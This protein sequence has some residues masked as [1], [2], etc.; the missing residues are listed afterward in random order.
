MAGSAISSIFR[1]GLFNN[2]VA[3][4]TGGGTGIG[5]TITKELLFL[6]CK[7]VIASRRV[8][9]LQSAT[10]ELKRIIDPS[11]TADVSFVQCNIR[12]EEEVKHLISTTL[13][14]YGKLD[15]LVNNGGGQFYSPAEKITLKGWNAV[16]ETN[17]TGTFLMCREAYIQWMENHGG[18]IVTIITDMWKGWPS[19]SHSGAAR[20][21]V[22]NLTKSLAIEWAHTGVRVNC[23]APGSSIYSDT[24][25]A[26]Y[27]SRDFFGKNL[28]IVPAK[29]FGTTEEVS[30]AVCFLL[31][32]AAAFITGE[33]IKVDAGASLY[34]TSWEI[35]EHSKSKPYT[36]KDDLQEES[37]PSTTECAKSKL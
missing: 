10:E 14:Q 16:I 9:N 28:H 30:A 25:A 20:A 21:G 22:D 29:R 4:V 26:N 3:I 7:V 27:G 37:K 5:K 32:P 11:S 35:P 31:S 23:V 12:K 36:W 17:L 24:A 15:F 1:R 19:M 33:T 6:G 8:E 34:G 13:E 2:K 18:V